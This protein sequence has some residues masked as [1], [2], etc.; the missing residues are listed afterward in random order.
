QAA[1]LLRRSLQVATVGL[2][3]KTIL[4]EHHG[5]EWPINRTRTP[6]ILNTELLC[7]LVLCF[8]RDV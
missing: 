7:F 1:L 8:S 6:A 5:M 2:D 4:E 3:E